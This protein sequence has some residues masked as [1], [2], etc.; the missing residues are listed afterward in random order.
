[1]KLI[2]AT[3]LQYCLG[4]NFGAI[5]YLIYSLHLFTVS[6]L[7]IKKRRE[8]Q[9]LMAKKE[10]SCKH[11]NFY[12]IWK[13]SDWENPIYRL[14]FSSSLC[15][16]PLSWLH[17]AHPLSYFLSSF[18]LLHTK[19][20]LAELIHHFFSLLSYFL[21]FLIS[22]PEG[23]VCLLTSWSKNSTGLR[24]APIIRAWQGA[25]VSTCQTNKHPLWH[26]PGHV[27]RGVSQPPR[28]GP[29]I[30]VW[31]HC[32][33]TSTFLICSGRG[34]VVLQCAA[35]LMTLTVYSWSLYF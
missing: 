10:N 19:Q 24:L 32:A 6:S 33:Y 27:W 4:T 18:F 22:T 31:A 23:V 3:F 9:L 28:S 34:A 21:F 20:A 25:A 15:L 11:D 26:P 5:D 14:L 13:I 1:M 30:S 29:V 2:Q 35:I 12:I 17:V 16:S 7:W 8:R